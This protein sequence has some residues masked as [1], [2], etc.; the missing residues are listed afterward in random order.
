MKRK[1]SKFMSV[2]LATAIIVTS[3][4]SSVFADIRTT[5]NTEEFKQELVRNM[6]NRET[7]FTINF[8]GDSKTFIS[9]INATI[10]QAYESDD[11]LRWSWTSLKPTASG[12]TNNVNIK[13]AASYVTTKEQEDFIDSEVERILNRI[14]ND[15]MSEKEKIQAINTWITDNISY[16]Y[17]L[18]KRSAYNALVDKS[19]VCQGYSLLMDK[20]VEALGMRS[21]IVTGNIPTGF[22]AWNLI[23]IDGKWYHVDSTNNSVNSNSEK[24]FLLSD[25]ELSS[26]NYSWNKGEFPSA[27]ESYVDAPI[28]PVVPEFP[29]EPVLPVLPVEPIEPTIPETPV[30]PDVPVVPETP[31]IPEKPVVDSEQVKM[32]ESAEKSVK[33]AES[34]KNSRYITAAETAISKVNSGSEKDALIERLNA[35][36]LEIEKNAD[37]ANIKTATSWVERA[38][39]YKSD[40]YIRYAYQYIEKVGDS[41]IKSQ[42]TARVDAVKNE[43]FKEEAIS[44]G[45]VPIKTPDVPQSDGQKTPVN[46]EKDIKSA[47]NAVEALERYGH[48]IY[49]NRAKDSVS[50]LN[51][52]SEKTLLLTRISKVEELKNQEAALKEAQR[53]E[54]IVT[55]AEAL[56][57]EKYIESTTAKVQEMTDTDKRAELMDRLESTK[58]QIDTQKIRL[59][60]EKAEKYKTANYVKE[61]KELIEKL[62]DSD[63]KDEYMERVEKISAE[64]M[65]KELDTAETWVAR[66]EKTPTKSMFAYTQKILDKLDDSDKKDSLVERLNAVSLLA[67]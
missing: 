66:A 52:S 42:L 6:V 21:Q 32:I 44:R 56:K 17:S 35:V 5:T 19:T 15:E 65:Q 61:A 57:N 24:Y 67:A 27:S 29:I 18:V 12:V 9:K 26:Y 23:N 4:A 43:V 20:M 36:K 58:S 50:S 53:L 8:Q 47:T 22:H 31:I 10:K 64:I 48:D 37:L 3:G 49:L 41:T 40:S 34:Y 59:A 1:I 25:D 13:F 63:I 60:V 38:E 16:D 2:A 46:S 62:D 28:I 30:T 7:D 33:L 45:D 51:D 39:K 54:S 14:I 11:Y 55:K